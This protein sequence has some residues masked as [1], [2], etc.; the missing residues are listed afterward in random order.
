MNTP[1]YTITIEVRTVRPLG[2][3]SI[4][5]ILGNLAEHLEEERRSGTKGFRA[6]LG[7]DGPRIMRTA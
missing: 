2:P 3:G 7:V 5:T 6:L 4:T 1:A